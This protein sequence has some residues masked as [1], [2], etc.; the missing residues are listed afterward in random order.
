MW[1]DFGVDSVWSQSKYSGCGNCFSVF[2]IEEETFMKC[3]PGMTDAGE[4]DVLA[5]NKLIYGLVQAARQH[6]R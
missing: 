1:F 2:N 4:N 6:W 3:Q 5:L